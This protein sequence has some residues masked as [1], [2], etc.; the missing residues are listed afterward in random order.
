MNRRLLLIAGLGLLA[1]CATVPGPTARSAPAPHPELEH[2]YAARAGKD[3][4]VIEVASNGCTKKEDFAFYLERRLQAATLSLARKRLDACRSFAM[5]K[6]ELT[7]TWAELGIERPE[8]VFLLNPLI[9][10]TGPGT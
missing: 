7:F 6:A 5:G 3:A 2:L 10:W 1:G 4:L 9:A 8:A